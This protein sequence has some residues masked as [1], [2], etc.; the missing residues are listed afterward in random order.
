M[1]FKIVILF[2]SLV[3]MFWSAEFSFVEP[4]QG[5]MYVDDYFNTLG[6]PDLEY[7]EICGG[8]PEK[9]SYYIKNQDG[10]YLEEYHEDENNKLSFYGKARYRENAYLF[11][12]RSYRV[13]DLSDKEY[14]L[15]DQ[16][17]DKLYF[18]VSLPWKKLAVFPLINK[19]I[20]VVTKES[21]IEYSPEGEVLKIPLPRSVEFVYIGNSPDGFVS[22]I[23]VGDNDI[24]FMNYRGEKTQFIVD[25]N[26]LSTYGDRMGILSIYPENESISYSAVYRYMNPYNKG[27]VLYQIDFSNGTFI[28]GFLFNSEDRNIGFD[29]SVYTSGEEVIVSARNSTE[30]G[31]V[32]FVIPKNEVAKIEGAVPEHIQGFEGEKT[33]EFQFSA[34][35][36]LLTWKAGSTVKKDDVTYAEVTYDMSNSLFYGVSMEGRVGKT[37]LA[38]SYLRNKAEEKGG[39]TAKVSEYISAVVDFNDLIGK[40]RTLRIGYEK[41][42]INGIA[43]FKS[44]AVSRFTVFETDLTLYYGYLMME[45]GLYAGLEYYNY[46]IPSAVGF[47]DWN[48]TVVFYDLDPNF[49]LYSLMYVVGY[50]KVSYTRRYE[51]NLSDF[52][53]AGNIGL[54]L[55][56][57]KV[58]KDIEDR[59]KA[60]TGA[61]SISIPLYTLV[62]AYGELG[63]IYQRRAKVLKGLGISVNLGYRLTFLRTIAESEGGSDPFELNLEFERYDLLHGPFLQANLIF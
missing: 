15:I 33:M 10:I 35:A 4:V 20:L 56:F 34:R 22:M 62:K 36:S 8:Q 2:I 9:C 11:V 37:Q 12:K 53:F 25:S 58:S 18:N 61:T 16:Y 7:G 45:R 48:G 30:G 17:G 63:Y 19:N 1:F 3:S 59:A 26:V 27:L 54:G 46:R 52:Y 29:P 49:T 44:G 14:Y 60:S 28:R 31:Y 42:R 47:S 50:D 57:A 21:V 41:G 39:L 5:K 43:R 32:H 13:G 24:V 40:R 23:A 38:V 51:V 55:G 6:M